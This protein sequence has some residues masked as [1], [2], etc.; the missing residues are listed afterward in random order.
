MTVSPIFAPEAPPN[1]G[2]GSAHLNRKTVINYHPP[3]GCA[4]ERG[5]GRR[6]A[7]TGRTPG[8]LV[9]GEFR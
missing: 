3:H 7:R 2:E 5:L 8:V 9:P 6:A 4:P 1:L